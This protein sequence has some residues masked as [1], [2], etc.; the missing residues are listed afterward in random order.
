MGTDRMVA[1]QTQSPLAYFKPKSFKL[2]ATTFYSLARSL[3]GLIMGKAVE[4]A[5]LITNCPAHGHLMYPSCLGWDVKSFQNS[6]QKKKK[7]KFV[8]SEIS[9]RPN[10]NFRKNL[11]TSDFSLQESVSRQCHRTIE[12]R[13][14]E[15]FFLSP[16]TLQSKHV[17]SFWIC[18]YPILSFTQVPPV[19]IYLKWGK[20][21]N[22]KSS[23][24]PAFCLSSLEGQ[25]VLG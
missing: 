13:R 3:F 5:K 8:E 4:R 14:S 1:R 7:K 17:C 12:Y 2:A 20:R 25:A 24:F 21:E 10:T 16:S 23:S 9:N 22:E 18:V 15:R 11:A 19:S 6:K